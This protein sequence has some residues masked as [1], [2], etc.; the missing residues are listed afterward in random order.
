MKGIRK[1]LC[2]FVSAVLFL[3]LG[4]SAGAATAGDDVLSAKEQSIIVISAVAAQGDLDKLRTALAEGLDHGGLTVNEEKEILIQLY[5]YAGFPRSLNGLNTLLAV[6]NERREAGIADNMGPDA[7]PADPAR[8]RYAAGDAIQTKLVGQ[9]VRGA[10]YD[11]APTISRFLKEH[12]FCDIFER[13]ILTWK[14]REFATVSMLAAIG[15][16][17]AQLGSHMRVGMHNGITGGQLKALAA[18]LGQR[19]SEAAGRNAMNAAESIV[20]G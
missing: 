6:V 11:F 10:V 1:K 13:G 20:D 7:A 3:A 9:P 17:N 19:V 2:L 4:G 8:D 5:A 12:L 16:V 18:L 15:N 14:E